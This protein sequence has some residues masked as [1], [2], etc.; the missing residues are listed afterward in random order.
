MIKLNY[1]EK[2]LDG[3]EVNW[4]NLG[5][6]HFIKIANSGRKPVK[7]SLRVSGKTPYYG[8]NNVQDYVEGY[9]HD[10]EFLLIAED[11]SASL[12]K[13]S[14]QYANGKFWANN[15]VHVLCGEDGLNTRFLYH[16][17]SAF[18]FN[19][20]LTGGSR[21]KLTKGNMIEIPVP[22]PPLEIQTEIV[23]ILDTFP[24]LIAELTSELGARKQQYNYYRKQLFTNSDF[25]VVKLES[26]AD[27][28]LGLTYTPTYIDDGIKFISAKNTSKDFLDLTDVKYISKEEYQRST[29]NAKPKRGDVLFTRVGSNLGHPVIVDTDEELCIFVSL[30]F[31]RVDSRKV[32]NSYIKHWINT[33]LFWSQ[34][35][36]KAYG[37]AKINLNTGWLKNFDVLLPSLPEQQRI[38]T[39]L[40]KFD[41]L[42]TSLTE[43]LPR[44]I[45]LRQQ[46]Y[47]YYRELLLSFPKPD[48]V[49]A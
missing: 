29:S 28:Y 9:T 4:T 11:G 38:V 23:R 46:Q 36:K 48:E 14:I 45:E 7:S 13:Y 24:T 16:Y 49:T 15:H 5:D 37:A 8:A 18:N 21:A 27:I 1:L 17:L 26:I 33:D 34:I 6:G 35:R 44:E 40:D 22:I 2:L 20:F 12:D 39:I 25:E 41:T 43:G 32:L 47:E 3:V 31:I 42:T 30:G 19:P 10:G